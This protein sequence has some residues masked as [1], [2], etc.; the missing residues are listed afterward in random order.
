MFTGNTNNIGIV[1][2]WLTAPTRVRFVRFRATDV[3]GNHICVRLEFYGGRDSQGM[4]GSIHRLLSMVAFNALHVSL[5]TPGSCSCDFKKRARH[6]SSQLLK[7]YYCLKLLFLFDFV[8]SAA[9]RAIYPL[10]MENG[11]IEDSQLSH[12]SELNG[13]PST[14]GRLNRAGAA[15]C[16]SRADNNEWL[17]IDFKQP[18]VI[19]AI[20]TQG[21]GIASSRDRT[22]K[23]YLQYREVGS[24]TFQ[25]AKN[26]T[27]GNMVRCFLA[28]FRIKHYF[29]TTKTRKFIHASKLGGSLSRC[30]PEAQEWRAQCSLFISSILKFTVTLQPF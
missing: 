19:T 16:V 10:G 5:Q 28:L 7:S 14:N 9:G 15:W 23:Y 24:T 4:I 13:N 30:W 1:Y 18:L 3:S 26:S 2:N 27:N 17:Q 8:Y 25:Y 21:H 6:Y 11:V 12:S 22:Y 29:A 20:A